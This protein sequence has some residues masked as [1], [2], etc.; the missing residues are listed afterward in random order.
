VPKHDVKCLDV[1][2]RGAKS[3]VISVFRFTSLLAVTSNVANYNYTLHPT[4]VTR[5]T[6]GLFL[7]YYETAGA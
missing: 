6:L 4:A 5:N 2:I 3:F 7:I 1:T